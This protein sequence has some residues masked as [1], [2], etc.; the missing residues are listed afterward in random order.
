MDSG[1]PGRFRV[2]GELVTVGTGSA[3]LF[4]LK[5][6]L[7][8]H[9]AHGVQETERLVV[10]YDPDVH[11]THVAQSSGQVS[12]G[13]S[14]LWAVNGTVSTLLLVV[15]IARPLKYSFYWY[16]CSL[17][18]SWVTVGIHWSLLVVTTKKM[19]PLSRSLEA[20]APR[21]W[22]PLLGGK[23]REPEG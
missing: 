16:F 11:L 12:C 1:N 9:H 5:P 19:V 2:P 20:P 13:G 6:S 8:S 14:G 3:C 21:G 18:L 10:S 4:W 7:E 22:K 23:A 17:L 15:G